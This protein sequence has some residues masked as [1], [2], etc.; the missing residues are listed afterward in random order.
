MITT[1]VAFVRIQVMTVPD[2]IPIHRAVWCACAEYTILNIGGIQ[3]LRHP[4]A[5]FK[6][7]AIDPP[8]PIGK[9]RESFIEVKCFK[10]DKACGVNGS[11]PILISTK[12]VGA[13][14]KKNFSFLA[15]PPTTNRLW[16]WLRPKAAL[17]STSKVAS[18]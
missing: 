18:T 15:S 4:N 10:M 13:L 7:N 17:P 6:Q 1:P 8:N 14:I 3:I 5:F 2:A 12:V 16:C 9:N 11:V